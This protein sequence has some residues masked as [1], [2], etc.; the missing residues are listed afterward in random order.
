[1]VYLSFLLFEQRCNIALVY[2]Y[3]GYIMS[4]LKNILF[5]ILAI[6]N[7]NIFV[8]IYMVLIIGNIFEVMVILIYYYGYYQSFDQDE[9]SYNVCIYSLAT[10]YYLWFIAYLYSNVYQV[11][12]L[13]IIV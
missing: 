9:Y 10:D 11:K 3:L 13:G 2:T 1:M 8:S 12:K 5:V 4:A 6:L 7:K